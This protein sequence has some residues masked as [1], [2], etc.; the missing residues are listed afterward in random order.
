MESYKREDKGCE[1]GEEQRGEITEPGKNTGSRGVGKDPFGHPSVKAFA[2]GEKNCGRP[3]IFNVSLSLSLSSSFL[4][5][6]Y[7]R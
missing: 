3:A 2:S 4:A 5:I 7:A 1:N 6:F